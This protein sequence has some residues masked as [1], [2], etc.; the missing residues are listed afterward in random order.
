PSEEEARMTKAL[1]YLITGL[2][3]LAAITAGRD[4]TAGSRQYDCVIE[5]DM[6]TEIGSPISGIIGEVLVDRGDMVKAGTVVARLRSEIEEATLEIAKA[7]AL[8][9]LPVDIARSKADLTKK[10]LD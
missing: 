4:A 8:T 9:T 7:R 2:I 6:V 5:P 10:E 3:A 1:N